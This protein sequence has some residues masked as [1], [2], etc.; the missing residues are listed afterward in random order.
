MIHLSRRVQQMSPSPTL[1]MTK[2]ALELKAEGMDIIALSLGEPD[3]NTPEHAEEAGIAAIR[4]HFTKYTAVDG[5]AQMKAAIQRKFQRD[6]GLEFAADEITVSSGSKIVLYNAIMATVDPGDEVI[7]PAPYWVSYPDMVKLADGVPVFVTGA[8]NNGFRM[9]PE[10]LQQAITPRTRMLILNSP[11]NPSGA[12]YSAHDLKALAAVLLRHPRV[13]VLTDEIYEH[14]VYDDF[15]TASIA[16]VEPR[17]ADRTITSNGM[18]KGYGMTGWR[19][20]FAGGPRTLIR[21]IADLQSQNVNA[22]NTISQYA[23]VAAL[24][25][26]QDYLRERAALY[27]QR[28]DLAVDRLNA[29]PGLA[30]HRPEGA[31]YLYPHCAGIIGKRTA[32]GQLIETDED[33]VL[34]LLDTQGV[35]AVHGGAFGLSPYFRISYALSTDELEEGLSRIAR[36]C[37]TLT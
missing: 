24:D 27:K 31:F 14:L 16:A 37:A 4:A 20:G 19:I 3:F 22:P 21:A 34:A 5:M 6:N 1:S 23:S 8:Q 10:D 15:Q 29:I 30:C 32:H 18:A 17:L 33:F 7:I 11:N 25:G 2:R 26:P 12:A 36:F 9:R 13:V 35:A 28:R